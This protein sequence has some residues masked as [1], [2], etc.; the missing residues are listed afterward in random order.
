MTLEKEESNSK[1]SEDRRSTLDKW[2]GNHATSMIVAI[3]FIF[4]LICFVV[5]LI[6]YK[7]TTDKISNTI[8]T[9]FFSLLSA[10]G[11]YFLA[12]LKN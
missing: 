1:G 3:L 10:L 5:Y 9:G 11:G 2:W 4:T 6:C 12:S 8:V 7:D